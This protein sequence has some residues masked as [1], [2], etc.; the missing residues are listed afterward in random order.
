[1]DKF[2]LN[3]KPIGD[4]SILVEW[5]Q[6]IDEEIL[7]DVVR[8]KNKIEIHYAKEKV[9]IN[10]AYCSLLITYNDTINNFYDVFSALKT[11]YSLKIDKVETQK[12]IWNI[13]VCYDSEYATDLLN[14][15]EEKELSI[16][17]IIELHSSSI[18]T[19][20]FIGFLPGFMYLGGLE[21]KLHFPRKST[22]DLYVKKGSVAIGGKQTGIYPQDSPGGWHIIGKS[23]IELFNSSNEKPCFVSEG[24]KVRFVSVDKNT[25]LNIQSLAEAGVY[26]P[27]SEDYH[28]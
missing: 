28:D 12:K 8:F 9:E 6:L 27:K 1:L 25:Y 7:D 10:I 24:D 20:Y 23:P 15:S 11:M 5:P 22:P 17:E 2:N 21:E 4:R 3:Y 14:Y 16:D 19:V 13:P 18:Y 26:V